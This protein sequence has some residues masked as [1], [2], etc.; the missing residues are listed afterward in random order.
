MLVKGHHIEG[1]DT[2]IVMGADHA[3][4]SKDF[5][6]HEGLLAQ[7]YQVIGRSGRD[8]QDAQVLIQTQ[9]PDHPIWSLLLDNDYLTSAHE[10]LSER[11]KYAL[12][13]YSQQISLLIASKK[14]TKTQFWS[15]K[16]H[17]VH[18]EAISTRDYWPSQPLA[19]HAQQRT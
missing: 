12:P 18:P 16:T 3:L 19:G 8:G 9:H 7:M 10:L 2:V 11:K 13:P 5:R 1:L 15:K 6:A 14:Q 4:Y 17:R